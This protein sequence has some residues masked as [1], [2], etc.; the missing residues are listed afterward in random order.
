MALPFAFANCN[1]PGR[2]EGNGNVGTLLLI[3]KTTD[4]VP[5]SSLVF[6]FT[7]PI[8][9]STFELSDALTVGLADGIAT[10]SGRVELDP[11]PPH[12]TSPADRAEAPAMDKVA[13]KSPFTIS[14]P[15][16]DRDARC[17]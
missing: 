1:T 7:P 4:P 16:G 9:V 2:G 15:K 11:P 3:T 12:A 14:L 13:F 10:L 8:F 5:P 6:R 17:D